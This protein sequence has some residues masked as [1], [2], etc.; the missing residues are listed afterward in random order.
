MFWERLG[1]GLFDSGR[2]ARRARD[3]RT[4]WIQATY[5]PVFGADGKLCKIV[6]F[7]SDISREMSLETELQQRL[8]EAQRFRADLEDRGKDFEAMMREVSQIVAS[9]N[10]I[11]AQTNL[12]ALNATIEAARAGEA[13]RGFAVVASEVKK[14][15]SDTKSAT[16]S[17]ALMM[18][19]RIGAIANA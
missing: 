16:E 4:I 6:K 15:A 18:S 5:N 1:E 19:T 14:L 12:L 10:E 17:A 13:G 2:Y 3:G 8:A 9:I 11:A 7:A